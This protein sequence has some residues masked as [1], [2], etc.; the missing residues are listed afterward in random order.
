MAKRGSTSETWIDNKRGSKSETW[1]DKRSV[2]RESEAWVGGCGSRTW[3]TTCTTNLS[4][5]TRWR[6]ASNLFVV[7]KFTKDWPSLHIYL[8]GEPLF[9]RFQVLS[10]VKESWEILMNEIHYVKPMAT[11]AVQLTAKARYS[12]KSKEEVTAVNVPRIFG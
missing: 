11:E 8:L 4:T 9:D 2:D 10:L 6:G 1:V 12:G 3:I 7:D 5:A